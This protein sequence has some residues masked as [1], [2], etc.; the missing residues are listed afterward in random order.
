MQAIPFLYS[1]SSELHQ[2]SLC[3]SE[4]EHPPDI[5]NPSK[6][7]FS[8][9][10]RFC[11]NPWQPD[12][13]PDTIPDRHAVTSKSPWAVINPGTVLGGARNGLSGIVRVSYKPH[14]LHATPVGSLAFVHSP[15]TPALRSQT[16][17]LPPAST[18][19]DRTRNGSNQ[20]TDCWFRY[21]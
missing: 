8:R 21:Y 18:H 12:E 13:D 11:R 7:T 9:P 6:T 14:P 1:H 19:T 16:T 17:D 2:R 15:I 3:M 4:V 5:D 20:Q 10:W